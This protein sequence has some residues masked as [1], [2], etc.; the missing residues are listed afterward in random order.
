[1]SRVNGF[2]P[3]TFCLILCTFAFFFLAS[4]L[5]VRTDFRLYRDGRVRADLEYSITPEA[6]EFGRG[7]GSDEPWFLPL[8][9]KD[10]RQQALRHPE[11]RI[12]RYRTSTD[13]DGIEH[14]SV[15]LD[16]QSVDALGSYLGLELKLEGDP[17]AGTLT[18][19]M[20]ADAG[21]NADPESLNR[22]SPFMDGVSFSFRF[23][24]PSRPQTV[25]MGEIDG[26]EAV[27]SISLTQLF[28]PGFAEDWVVTW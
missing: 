9:E 13:S 10:F 7:F 6:A 11:T 1:M 17:R 4:C 26:R 22:L 3:G 24:P 5:D 23:R 16:S 20:P 15:R 18:L 27:F 21:G 12:L 28:Q 8:T 19:A 2:R 25:S 14:V